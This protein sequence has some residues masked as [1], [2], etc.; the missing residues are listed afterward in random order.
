VCA[1]VSQ[2]AVL[3]VHAVLFVV[4]HSTQLIAVVSHAGRAGVL[5]SVSAL[6][7]VFIVT[8]V[9]AALQV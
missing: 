7:V 4:V 1:V 3:P 8:Q 9:L 5:Q 2:A 6:Q